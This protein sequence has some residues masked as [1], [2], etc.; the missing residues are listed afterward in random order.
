[1][2]GEK[3]RRNYTRYTV[4]YMLKLYQHLRS[5][6]HVLCRAST[7]FSV[8]IYQLA[9]VPVY[10]PFLI[11]QTLIIVMWKFRIRGKS[12]AKLHTFRDQFQIIVTTKCITIIIELSCSVWSQNLYYCCVWCH[13]VYNFPLI[14]NFQVKI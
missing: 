2:I 3:A 13:C 4:V 5:N 7:D 9:L 14:L 12:N 8:I 11:S 10:L 1:M 6:N